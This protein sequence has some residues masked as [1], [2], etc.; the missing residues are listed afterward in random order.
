MTPKFAV[1]LPAQGNLWRTQE[2]LDLGISKRS[3]ASM[4]AVGTLV[5]L[6][7]GCYIRGSAWER[8]SPG[9]RALQLIHAHAHGTRTTSAGGFR[10][11]HTSAARLHRLFLWNVDSKI[12]V[13][14]PTPPS[15]NGHGPDVVCHTGTVAEADRAFITGLA[16]TGLERTAAD[17]GL[18]LPYR[19][20]LILMDHALR[21]GADKAA[22]DAAAARLDGRRGVLNLRR[23]LAAAD[24]SSESPGE[25]LTRDLMARLRIPAPEPQVEV[26]TR[27][28]LFRLDFAW[29]ERKLA[30]EF[31]G[32]TKYFDYRPTAEVIFEE[33]RREKALSENGWRFIRVEW[34][35][36]FR[37]QEFKNL[38]LRALAA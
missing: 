38:I 16:A 32:K 4:V 6:R 19:Q 29:R 11:S 17:C 26:L 33:R 15:S 21:L 3:V 30:L 27:L 14:Q 24:P 10:Y 12:H 1:A 13:T 22:L 18:V 36:L 5:R 7:Q 34:K 28:G 9:V 23:V 35:D 20:A 25:T 2:L 37:E 31:D 8:Q